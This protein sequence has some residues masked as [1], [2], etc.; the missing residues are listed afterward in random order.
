MR[1][2]PVLTLVTSLITALSYRA[3][4]DLKLAFSCVPEPARTMPLTSKRDSAQQSAAPTTPRPLHLLRRVERKLEQLTVIDRRVV[5]DERGE[6]NRT[7]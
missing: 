6:L 1:N 3:A 4:G 2:L 5:Q 7:P